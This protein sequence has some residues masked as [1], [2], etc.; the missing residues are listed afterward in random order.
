[1]EISLCA[2][3]PG[4]VHFIMHFILISHFRL[5]TLPLRGPYGH[6]PGLATVYRDAGSHPTVH[7]LSPSREPCPSCL[8]P[9]YLALSLMLG[10]GLRRRLSAGAG[11]S[12]PR[13][14]VWVGRPWLLG[15]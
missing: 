8:A 12:G 15:G 6:T 13:A 1:M 9:A 10:A 2:P 11:G 7:V 5:Y 4:V 3:R 14:H